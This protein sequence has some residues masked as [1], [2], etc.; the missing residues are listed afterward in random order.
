[1]S[2]PRITKPIAVVDCNFIQRC[3]SEDDDVPR[4]WDCLLISAVFAELATKPD[5]ERAFLFGKFT[6]WTRRNIDRV[7]VAQDFNDL[8]EA[9]EPS[10][11]RVRQ[12]RLR[13]LV[14]PSRTRFLRNALRG[15]AAHW[16]APLEFPEVQQ[17]LSHAARARA[18]FVSF[19]DQCRD[20]IASQDGRPSEKIPHTKEAIREYVRRYN[21]ADLVVHRGGRGEYGDWR[22]RKHLE[23]FP[24]RLLIAR[25]ARLDLYYA[26]RRSL[27][28]SRKFE[29][30]W[31]DIHYAIA[32]SYTGH[33]ATHDG[34]LATAAEIIAP[35][36]FI[37]PQWSR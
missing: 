15:D 12:V 13:H 25:R 37:F 24:D 18:A 7:W 26:I 11:D 6:N 9:M 27:G 35:G 16:R 3:R 14:S 32:A 10:P 29:N 1:M 36:L 4:A 30:N 5:G 22:W 34:G 33:L 19:A 2:S 31:D 17:W 23:C 20:F 21:A 28:D 8:R